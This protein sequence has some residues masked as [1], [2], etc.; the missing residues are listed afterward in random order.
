MDRYLL[1]LAAVL[2]F[3]CE[4]ADDNDNVLPSSNTSFI[5]AASTPE[6]SLFAEALLLTGLDQ[7]L[8]GRVEFTVIAPTNDAFTSLLSAR[9]ISSISDFP[10][11]ELRTLLLY[12]LIPDEILSENF[13]NGYLSTRATNEDSESLDLYISNDAGLRFNGVGLDPV[14]TGKDVDNGIVY[15]LDGVLS[16]LTLDQLIALN[17]DLSN[18]QQALVQ[19]SLD[20]TLGINDGSS[21]PFTVF[22]PDN[23]AFTNFIDSDPMDAFDSVADV[24]ALS[25]LRDVLLFHVVSGDELRDENLVDTTVVDP[26]TSGNFT[27]DASSGSKRIILNSIDTAGF[28]S[29]NI[30]GINGV[31]HII[32]NILVP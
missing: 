10:V 26:V 19:E 27:I 21:D 8:Q 6:L 31:M 23:Q 15:V 11:E 12:H 22:A 16:L 4:D 18:L 5:Y 9:G 2:L 7:T 28:A 32:N 17:P 3:S 20:A 1:L 29:N 25:D 24:L 30:T 14:I 13:V